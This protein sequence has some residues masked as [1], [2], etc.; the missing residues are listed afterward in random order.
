[1]PFMAERVITSRP[2][3]STTGV[4]VATGVPG[5]AR[6]WLFPAGSA[7]G[8]ADERLVVFDPGGA[9]AHVSVVASG[10]SNA[11]TLSPLVVAPGTRQA[12]DLGR[13]DPATTLVL[14]VTSDVPIVAEREQFSAGGQGLSNT[15][16][17]AG[18]P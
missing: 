4:A 14:D 16:G 1:V 9:A 15:T 7:G 17:I 5:P 10:A 12:V 13:V 2:P 6:R 8:G 3:A 18:G 11:V